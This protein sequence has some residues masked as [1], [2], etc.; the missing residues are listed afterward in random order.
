MTSQRGLGALVGVV[1]AG[2]GLAASELT[3]GA[4]HQRVSP[5][6]AVAESVIRLTPGALAEKIIS[7][8][9]RNDKPLVILSTL[10]GLLV[11]SV[12]VGIVSMRSL[13]A[14]E[15]AFLAMGVILVL[16]VHARLTSSQATYLPAGVGVAIAMIVLATLTPRAVRA[17]RTT[18]QRSQDQLASSQP[19]SGSR[20]DFLRLAGVVAVGAVVV[21]GAGR[22]L[23]QGR[24][25]LDAARSKLKLPVTKPVEPP[26]VS[27]G[28]AGITPWNTSAENFY[29]IDTAL[30]IPEILPVDWSLRIHGMVDNELTLSFD[31]LLAFGLTEYWLTLCCVSNEVGGDLISNAWFS[32]VRIADV[33]KEVGVHADADAVL[34]TSDDG[35]TA[36]TPIGALT[37]NRNALFAVAMNGEPLEPEHGFPVRM[38]VPGLY[39]YV[40]ATKWVRDIEVTRFDDFSA[41]WTERGWSEQG[42]VKTESRIDVPNDG[43][44]VKAGRVA[45][46]GVAW[47][48]HTGIAKVEVNI[49]NTGWVEAKLSRDDT[50]DSWRQWAYVWTAEAGDH[51]IQVR[52]TDNSGY[53]QTG[54][55]AN[56]VPDGATGWHSINVSVD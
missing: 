23:A 20:R 11:L 47:A 30:S 4:L 54:D 29:R 46:G 32:G 43:D 37:D 24:A 56:V 3:S 16:A 44:R 40:S 22:V 27:V 48:Q 45:I 2:S 28:V 13:A 6:V 25:A 18:V 15:A 51:E 55:V 8:V 39:G 42:P 26:G 53:T 41:F 35:W 33:L 21:G 9:G 36:G 7:I 14:G 49:G 34:S 12:L 1:S 38:V 52:A 31:D 17:S 10:V 5:V 19:S 50:I